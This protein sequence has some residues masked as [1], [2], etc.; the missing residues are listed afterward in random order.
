LVGGS[1]IG[2]TGTNGGMLNLYD[3]NGS[4][5]VK[6]SI[7]G[8]SASGSG[9]VRMGN[10]KSV[11][12]GGSIIGGDLDSG[13]ATYN[14]ALNHYSGTI[15]SIT[16]GGSII[17]GSVSGSGSLLESGA[18]SLQNAGSVLIKGN[19]IAGEDN[20]SGTLSRSGAIQA[21][22]SIGAVTIKGHVTGSSTHRAV[23]A[24]FGPGTL[25]GSGTQELAIAK[26]AIGGN[27]TRADFLAGFD[28]SSGRDGD[29]SIGS[30]AVKG[31]WFASSISAGVID[32]GGT[33]FGGADDTISSDGNSPAITSRIASI[34]IGGTFGGT[35]GAGDTF[36]FVAQQIGLV[37]IGGSTVFT[38]TAATDAVKALP[39][40]TSDLYVRE[41]A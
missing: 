6:G 15:G 21:E 4:V 23:I 37:K 33:G 12:I 17:G 2:S 19:V 18:L 32:T 25:L 22:E 13:S 28:D 29:G 11:L 20:S 1:L 24:A 34:V 38:G 10:A 26:I 16:I 40:V 27:V 14:G 30:V 35:A 41:V 9:Q 39:S 31:D 5:T 8:G 3:V 36:G 7:I